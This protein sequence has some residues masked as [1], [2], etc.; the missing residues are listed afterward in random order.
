MLYLNPRRA[1]K[2][3]VHSFSVDFFQIP[4]AALLE[5]EPLTERYGVLMLIV[6]QEQKDENRVQDRCFVVLR[7][8]FTIRKPNLVLLFYALE[9]GANLS[10]ILLVI[11]N[12]LVYHDLG[13]SLVGGYIAL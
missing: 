6:Q 3:V 4:E 2:I 1:A 9:H 5:A 13:K 10:A 12:V 11:G 8:F 7:Y